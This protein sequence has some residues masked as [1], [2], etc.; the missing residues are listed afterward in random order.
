MEHSTPENVKKN[1]HHDLFTFW[2]MHSNSSIHID[3]NEKVFTQNIASK[4]FGV[5]DKK[6]TGG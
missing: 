6:K 1:I 3:T 2:K 5:L 4:Y